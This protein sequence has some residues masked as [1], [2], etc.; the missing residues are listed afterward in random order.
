MSALVPIIVSVVA[1]LAAIIGSIL[2][3]RAGKK[4]T[5]AEAAETLTNVALSLIHPLEET[6]NDLKAAVALQGKEIELL[7]R[8]NKLLHRW[9]QLL[10]SQV[11]EA[12]HDPI[13]FEKVQRMGKP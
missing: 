13:P 9:S 5:E 1:A 2:T 7:K 6:I 11:V 8:E 10:Y 3:V 12:G 4:K